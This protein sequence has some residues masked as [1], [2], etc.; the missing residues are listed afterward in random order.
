MLQMTSAARYMVLVRRL[1]PAGASMPYRRGMVAGCPR[2]TA[3][4]DVVN[5]AMPSHDMKLSVSSACRSSISGSGADDSTPVQPSRSEQTSSPFSD[6]HTETGMNLENKPQSVKGSSST[7]LRGGTW[8]KVTDF[9]KSNAV[10][11]EKLASLGFGAFCAYG[12]W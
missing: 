3:A 4:R 1:Q 10:T 6:T 9:F 2:P 12:G 7:P 5:V 8:Q 11:K